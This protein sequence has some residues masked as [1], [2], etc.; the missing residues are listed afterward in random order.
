MVNGSFSPLQKSDLK[1]RSAN[2][3]YC[4]KSFYEI[5]SIKV[6]MKIK[7]SVSIFILALAV[8]APLF[9]GSEVQSAETTPVKV[10][11]LFFNDIHGH[12]KPFKI[13]TES[14]FFTGTT[15]LPLLC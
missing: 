9:V 2:W 8:V 14:Y 11:I 6:K 12:L 5:L 15:L 13:R 7:R 4:K 3:G 10:T 1:N